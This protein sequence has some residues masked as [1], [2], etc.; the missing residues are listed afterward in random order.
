MKGVQRSFPLGERVCSQLLAQDCYVRDCCLKRDLQAVSSSPKYI[1]LQESVEDSGLKQEF[2]EVDYPITPAYVNS[3]VESCDYRRDPFGA[4]A[5]GGSRVNLGDITEM[6]S[7]ASM[8][9]EHARALYAQLSERFSR[10]PVEAQSSQE[11]NSIRNG[12]DNV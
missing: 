4:V 10:L 8:D 3:Y 2:V 7:V 9:T 5:R 1:T 12:V 6:Q 11:D